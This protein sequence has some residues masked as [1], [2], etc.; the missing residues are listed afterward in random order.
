LPN[1]WQTQF[2]NRVIHDLQEFEW[3]SNLMRNNPALRKKHKFRIERNAAG[4]FF[5]SFG[6]G[7]GSRV[8]RIGSFLM[9]RNSFTPLMR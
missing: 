6:E 7:A 1:G 2:Y 9:D 4:A 5:L 8:G 3:F